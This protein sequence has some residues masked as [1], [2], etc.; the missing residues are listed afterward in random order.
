LRAGL[1]QHVGAGARLLER[2]EHVAVEHPSSALTRIQLVLNDHRKISDNCFL[3]RSTENAAHLFGDEN[4]ING[5][6]EQWTISEDAFSRIEAYAQ[7]IDAA[8]IPSN[9]EAE[10]Q[11]TFQ[12]YLIKQLS[13]GT[14][15]VWFKGSKLA[16]SRPTLLTIEKQIYVETLYVT[17][18]V[19]NTRELGKRVLNALNPPA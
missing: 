14:I 11:A 13:T 12:D 7:I 16:M 19:A 1:Q 4:A 6:D 5:R 17:G 8:R 3:V 15:E 2:C 10:R 9:V 18:T